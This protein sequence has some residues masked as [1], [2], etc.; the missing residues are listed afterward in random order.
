MALWIVKAW[1]G[2]MLLILAAL[3]A[4]AGW[5]AWCGYKYSVRI[6]FPDGAPAAHAGIVIFREG[7]SQPLALEKRGWPLKA[8]ED[9]VYRIPRDFADDVDISVWRVRDGIGYGGRL[10]SREIQSWPMRIQM[11]SGKG[12]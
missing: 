10:R 8:D 12:G 6:S 5:K 2:L 3:L 4:A 9:G 7:N 1:R 11:A